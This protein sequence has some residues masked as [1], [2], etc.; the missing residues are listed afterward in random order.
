MTPIGFE[1]HKPSASAAAGHGNS[2]EIWR[3]RRPTWDAALQGRDAADDH[4]IIVTFREL[5]RTRRQRRESYLS[6]PNGFSV[7]VSLNSV[8]RLIS[9]ARRFPSCCS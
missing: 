1:G 6:P 3:R 2:I 8:G 4:E 9:E 7:V 5:A